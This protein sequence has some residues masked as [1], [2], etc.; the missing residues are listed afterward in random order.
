MELV[1]GSKVND[2]QCILG[3]MLVY[4]QIVY[5]LIVKFLYTDLEFPKWFSY[6][7][8]INMLL[9]SSITLLLVIQRKLDKRIIVMLGIIIGVLIFQSI[10]SLFRGNNL[11]LIIWGIRNF[12]RLPLFII[13]CTIF[14]KRQ[15][16]DKILQIIK[17][18]FYINAALI[19]FQWLIL[20]GNQDYLNGLFGYARG[21]NGP[22]NLML[23]IVMSYSILKI[24]NDEKKWE[25]INIL[26]V[27]YIATIVELKIVFIEAVVILVG[28]VLLS[29]RSKKT[30][31]L[32]IACAVAILI[33]IQILGLLYPDFKN[34]LNINFLISEY[35]HKGYGTYDNISR[36]NA[37][38]RINEQFFNS[39]KDLLF[40]LGLGSGQYSAYF[41][42]ALYAQYGQRITWSWFTHASLFLE[43]GIVG[44]VLYY[45]ILIYI[46]S[47]GVNIR[48]KVFRG[49][50]QKDNIE[51][52]VIIAL[53]GML[54]IMYDATI[55]LEPGCYL[56]GF[57]LSDVLIERKDMLKA[58]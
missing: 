19:T 34:F 55:S 4:F 15:D 31:Y 12:Y 24:L 39:W 5:A 42:S 52:A 36:V 33:S 38:P 37:I 14:L 26:L 18:C 49:S 21:G 9:L 51:L 20:K 22:L 41:E 13:Y 54:L 2:K 23:I 30:I 6:L 17:Y 28:A 10:Y 27:F 57:I 50:I 58:C 35:V 29:K 56:M 8:D 7:L 45:G 46:V 53:C 32:V 44:L 11:I 43:A 40:G 1:I 16:F 48:R 3:R 25:V 47:A